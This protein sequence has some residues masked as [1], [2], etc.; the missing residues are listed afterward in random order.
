MFA[1]LH[2]LNLAHGDIKPENIMFGNSGQPEIFSDSNSLI[3]LGPKEKF[4]EAK[5]KAEFCS[6]DW[7]SPEHFKAFEDKID[8]QR[9]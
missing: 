6:K 3:I 5:Y 4:K 7:A 1:Q 2:S 8:L 9:E